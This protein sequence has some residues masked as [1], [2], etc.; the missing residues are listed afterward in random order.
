MILRLGC[1]RVVILEFYRKPGDPKDS[2]NRG[3]SYEDMKKL[4]LRG[5]ILLNRR[6]RIYSTTRLEENRMSS[7]DP[8]LA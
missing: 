5:H 2:L 7:F 1:H 8:S 4:G 3:Y 6:E